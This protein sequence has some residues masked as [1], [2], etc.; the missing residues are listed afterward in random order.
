MPNSTDYRLVIDSEFKRVHESLAFIKEQ[1]TKTNDR[2]NHL[3]DKVEGIQVD[4]LEYQFF[5]KYPKV[6]IMLIALFVIMSVFTIYRGFKAP[7]EISEVKQE[8]Q[9]E[10]RMHGGVP[11]VIRGVGDKVYMK[12]NDQGLQDTIRIR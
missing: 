10:I 5:K 4:L 11:N 3:E 6:A 1:T 2:V 8:I 12:I 9:D 7:A